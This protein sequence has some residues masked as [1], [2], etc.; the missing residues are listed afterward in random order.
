MTDYEKSLLV[1]VKMA[2]A[3]PGHD[4]WTTLTHAIWHCRWGS[5]PRDREPTEADLQAVK[6][7][8]DLRIALSL[9]ITK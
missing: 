1:E 9:R 6:I 8:T 2:T 7:L 3:K 5:E 4:A